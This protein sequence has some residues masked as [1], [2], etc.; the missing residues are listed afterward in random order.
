MDWRWPEKEVCLWDARERFWE[1][2]GGH[3]DFGS[4]DGTEFSK[5]SIESY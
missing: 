1:C 4:S 2:D 5:V 3:I